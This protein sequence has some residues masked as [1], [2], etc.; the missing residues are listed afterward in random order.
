MRSLVFPKKF[1]WGVAMAAP[2]IEGASFTDGKGPSIW[3]T[4]SRIPGKIRRGETPDIACDHYHRYRDDFALMAKLG[5]KHYRLSIAW[6]RIFPL[7]R[8]AVNQAGIDYYQSLIDTL[9]AHGI[10]PWVTMFHRDLP[11]ALEDQGGWRVRKTVDAFAAYADLIVKTY[12]DRVKHWIT[13]NG[14]ACF[15]SLGY[16][17]SRKAPGAQEKEGVFNQACHHAL[18]CHGHGVRAVREHGR[19]GS[20]V[21]LADNPVVSVPVTETTRDIDAAKKAFV[22]DNIRVL[23]PLFRGRYAP[24]YLRAVGK[25][26][27]KSY[28]HD[29]E[30]IG[31]PTDFI[32][33]NIHTGCFVRAS[34]HGNPER[35]PFPTGYPRADSPWIYNIPQAIHWAPRFVAEI[36]GARTVYITGNGT[37]YSD[38]PPVNDEVIDLHRREYLRNHLCELHGAIALG[39]PVKGYFLR[40]FLDNFEWEEGYEHRFGIVYVDFVTQQRT[41]KL[42]AQW[43][44]RVMAENRIV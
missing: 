14:I 32:G 8:D 1:V 12:G 22:A 10:T 26:A 25:S 18:L 43:Y 24:S 41:P 5:V 37:G 39:A 29:F 40:S 36:Y 15:T 6:P 2:Q 4:F 35:L 33:L 9:L 31:L 17:S 30:L 34:K 42:S 38:P 23:D 16:G 44:A 28:K 11:Q 3:D 21:G 27:P 7:G 19:R 20:F 13:L